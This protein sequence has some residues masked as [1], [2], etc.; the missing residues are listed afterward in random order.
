MA[1]IID[2]PTGKKIGILAPW[3]EMQYGDSEFK[4]AVQYDP[5]NPDVVGTDDIS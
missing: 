1:R 3:G 5:Q 4:I 2:N